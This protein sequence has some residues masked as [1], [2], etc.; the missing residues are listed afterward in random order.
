MPHGRRRVAIGVRR[1]AIGLMRAA[2]GV[3]REASGE[4]AADDW[5]ASRLTL[6]ADRCPPNGHTTSA[7]WRWGHD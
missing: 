6:Y 4:W 2:R 5:R 3:R 7:I 1:E